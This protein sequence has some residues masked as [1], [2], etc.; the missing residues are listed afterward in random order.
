MKI[1]SFSFGNIK[2]E[3]STYTRDVIIYPNRIDANWWRKEGHS[4]IPEDIQEV[5]KERPEVLIVGCGVSGCLT[6]PRK[7][8]EELLR[9]GIELISLPTEDAISEYNKLSPTKNVIAC[10]HLTC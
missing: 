7:T 10:L 8:Q 9:K 4:L 5:I 1:E 2:V 6:I 3:G